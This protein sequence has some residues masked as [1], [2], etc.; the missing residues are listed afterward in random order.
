MVNVKWSKR[1]LRNSIVAYGFMAPALILLIIFVFYPII[2]SLPLAFFDYSIIGKSVF[3]GWDNF[4]RAFNDTTFWAS[5]KNSVVFIL[6]VPPIQ[7]LAI[8][9]AILV[10]KEIPGIKF[11]RVLF[12]IPVVTSL[13][14]VSIIWKFIFDPN[15]ILNTFLMNIGVIRDPIMWLTS[16][17]LALGM[18][19][20]ITLWQGLGYFMMIYLGGLQGIPKE[21]EEAGMIDGASKF[22]ILTRIKL[23]LLRPY[24]VL[25]TFLSLLSAISVFDIMFVITDGTGSP[26]GATMV[27]ALYTFKKAFVDFEFGYSASLGL[28]VAVITTILS[29]AIFVYGNKGGTKENNG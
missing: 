14:A 1:K 28:L 29:V 24:V 18:M 23:P 13:V 25:C 4:T 16:S 11:F 7:I 21:L 6:V 22:T 10:N 3:I 15:G 9:L 12:Y 5:L 19:M 17:K 8:L 2:Y 27:Q 20:F 26:N